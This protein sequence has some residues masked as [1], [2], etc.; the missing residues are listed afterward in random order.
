MRTEVSFARV[1]TRCNGKGSKAHLPS[2]GDNVGVVVERLVERN[3]G[4]VEEPDTVF[5]L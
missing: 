4:Q 5:G 1:R 2:V 3:G